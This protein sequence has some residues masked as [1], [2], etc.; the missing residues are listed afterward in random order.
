MRE[1]S[2]KTGVMRVEML[3]MFGNTE[4]FFI[5]RGRVFVVINLKIISYFTFVMQC[6]CLQ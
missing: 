6:N 1:E 4:N 2:L 3:F 5:F